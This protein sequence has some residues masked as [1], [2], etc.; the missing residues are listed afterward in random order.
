MMDILRQKLAKR[1]V[2]PKAIDPQDPV[3]TPNAARQEVR[4]KQ[5]CRHRYGPCGD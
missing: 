4:L 3:T 2:D 5:G 1:S